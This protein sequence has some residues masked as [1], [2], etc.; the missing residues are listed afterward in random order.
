MMTLSGIFGRLAASLKRQRLRLSWSEALL[1]G[2]HCMDVDKI[3][4]L[5]FLGLESLYSEFTESH[6]E[7]LKEQ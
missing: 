3:T 2:T 4:T 7:I 5:R 1:F 6:L